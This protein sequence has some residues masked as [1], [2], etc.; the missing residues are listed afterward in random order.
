[1]LEVA[2]TSVVVKELPAEQESVLCCFEWEIE[3]VCLSRIAE[4]VLRQFA[5]VL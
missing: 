4:V 3:K 1:M 2:Q 5:E